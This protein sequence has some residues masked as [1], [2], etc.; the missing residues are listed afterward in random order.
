MGDKSETIVNTFYI[1]L[2]IY[3][4]NI[5]MCVRLHVE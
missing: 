4:F 5:W 1:F 2:N 3:T